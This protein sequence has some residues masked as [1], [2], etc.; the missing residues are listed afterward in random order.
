MLHLADE[1]QLM[2]LALYLQDGAVL[3]IAD[4]HLGFEQALNEEGVLVPRS[5]LKHIEQRLRAVSSSGSNSL[6]SSTR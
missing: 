6:Q 5:H 4:L 1:L 2:D 3:A